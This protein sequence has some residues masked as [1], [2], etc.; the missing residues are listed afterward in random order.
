[1]EAEDEDAEDTVE[2][3]DGFMRDCSALD[4]SFPFTVQLLKGCSNAFFVEVC[5]ERTLDV[6]SHSLDLITVPHEQSYRA[7]GR[8]YIILGLAAKCCTSIW[9]GVHCLEVDLASGQH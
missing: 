9:K 4:S 1:M 5:I 3:F 8:V 2:V 7:G 6:M